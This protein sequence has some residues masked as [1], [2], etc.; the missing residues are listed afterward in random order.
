MG[1]DKVAASFAEAVLSRGEDT[2]RDL[3]VAWAECQVSWRDSRAQTFGARVVTP[4][5]TST[6]SSL[7][8]FKTFAAFWR[9]AASII[10]DLDL[11]PLDADEGELERRQSRAATDWRRVE[12]R[13]RSDFS[14]TFG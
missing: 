2:V 14:V 4:L 11:I 13:S 6:R 5:V 9:R 3:E 1:S 8:T 7:E 12:G 10:G